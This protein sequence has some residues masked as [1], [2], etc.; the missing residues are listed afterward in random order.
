MQASCHGPKTRGIGK[1]S[2]LARRP[3]AS[4]A[5]TRRQVKHRAP[6]QHTQYSRGLATWGCPSSLWLPCQAVIYAI[7]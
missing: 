1:E 5:R 4:S 7:P 2:N 6:K 3:L